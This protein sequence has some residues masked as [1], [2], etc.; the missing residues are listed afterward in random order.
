MNDNENIEEEEKINILALGNSNVGKTSYI[1]RYADN[2]YHTIYLATY[3]INFKIK[4]ITLPNQ[5]K[6]KILFY[7]TSGEEKFKSISLNTIKNADGM[8]LLYDITNQ[9]SFEAIPGLIKSVKEAKGGN[10]PIVLLG[11]KC[12]LENNRE[13]TKEEGKKLANEYNIG[14]FEISNKKGINIEESCLEL[15]NKIIENRE[16]N[17]VL[18]EEMMLRKN[19][20]ILRKSKISKKVNDSKCNC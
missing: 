14:F 9:D 11:N 3:G 5:K 7:D 20:V 6:I 1:L 19:S 10:I 4:I 13:I 2:I 18:K 17:E 16:K 15:I 12:D 8:A